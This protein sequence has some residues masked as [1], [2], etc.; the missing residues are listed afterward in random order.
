VERHSLQNDQ[1]EALI[2]HITRHLA[3]LDD[4]TLLSLADL[5]REAA[6]DTESVNVAGSPVSRRRFLTATLAGGFV[7]AT[8]G[9]I[10][11][12]QY[13]S[14][15]GQELTDDLARSKD[16][17]G[18]VWELVHLHE[19]LDD[20]GLENVV[21]AGLAAVGAALEAVAGAVNLVKIGAQAAEDVL[22]KFEATFPTIR[23]GLAWLESLVSDLSQRIHLL[24]DAIGRALNEVN[25]ITQALGAFFNS[26]INLIPLGG[27]QK[28]KE[29]LDR[30]GEI[31]NLVPQA[32]ADINVKI[33]TPLR[34]DWFSDDPD[35]GLKI[36]LIEPIVTRLL[37]PLEAL[38]DNWNKLVQHWEADLTEPTKIALDKREGI[39]KEIVDYKLR[40]R[41]QPP[42]S[43]AVSG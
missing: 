8:A 12:W 11:V 35:K 3:D 19:K 4:Q 25:P 42:R 10:A 36:S 27:G 20:M 31:V 38:M 26:V 17:L 43:N 21:T 33:L 34:N 15:R 40:N 29:V 6:L 9:A 28:I 2:G 24:E 5:T 14:G 32:I 1:R 13:G 30:I 16:D 37:D 23:D 22:K 7:A 39:R 41:L 18:R